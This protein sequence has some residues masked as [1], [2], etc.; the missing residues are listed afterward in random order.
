MTVMDLKSYGADGRSAL[1]S[2]HATTA[3][4]LPAGLRYNSRA[5][6]ALVI[7][8]APERILPF[9]NT[10]EADGQIL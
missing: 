6:K 3:P 5:R 2:V 1:V 8:L 7:V 4:D 9:E 10:H